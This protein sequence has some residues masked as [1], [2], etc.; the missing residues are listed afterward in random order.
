MSLKGLI[1]LRDA[2]GPCANP[3]KDAQRTKTDGRTRETLTIIWGAE[4]HAERLDTAT[5]WYRELLARAGA[6]TW[7][8]DLV[9]ADADSGR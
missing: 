7:P 6:E 9:P 1:C 4:G 5:A 3:V 2:E 8:I